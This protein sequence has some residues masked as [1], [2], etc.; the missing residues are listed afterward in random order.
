MGDVNLTVKT[1]G[2]NATGVDFTTDKVSATAGNNYFIQNNDGQIR[3]VVELTAVA[4]NLI[5]ETPNT[6]D[7]QAIAD[8]TVALTQNKTIVF[9][10]FPPAIYNDGQGRVKLTVSANTDILAFR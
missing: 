2:R 4:G 6:V 1:S 3:L 7:G 5:A 10:P 9:G 8:L